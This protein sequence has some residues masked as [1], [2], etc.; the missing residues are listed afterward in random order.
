MKNLDDNR[1][2]EHYVTHLWYFVFIISVPLLFLAASF[3]QTI[4]YDNALITIRNIQQPSYIHIVLLNGKFLIYTAMFWIVMQ[5]PFWRL[6]IAGLINNYGDTKVIRKLKKDKMETFKNG[7]KNA[8]KKDFYFKLIGIVIINIIFFIILN[9]KFSDSS[10]LMSIIR[11]FSLNIIV[12][13]VFPLLI[14]IMNTYHVGKET[15]AVNNVIIMLIP[16][17]ITIIFTIVITYFLIEPSLPNMHKQGLWQN[18]GVMLVI[19]LFLLLYSTQIGSKYSISNKGQHEKKDKSYYWVIAFSIF[20][21]GLAFLIVFLDFDYG[22]DY[23]QKLSKFFYRMHSL[24]PDVPDNIFY[25]DYLLKYKEF[26]D[27]HVWV[28]TVLCLFIGVVLST[29]LMSLIKVWAYYALNK[30]EKSENSKN[31]NN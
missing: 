10:L 30:T 1:S 4:L 20:V 28:R 25:K 12:F 26:Y 11:V 16:T 7:L 24:L 14:T 13:V 15:V 9:E 19:Y 27:N 29:V 2:A 17:L 21:V 31:N 18:V 3:A 22:R 8:F 23:M 5:I 6:G